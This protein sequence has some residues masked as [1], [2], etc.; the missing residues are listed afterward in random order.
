VLDALRGAGPGRSATLPARSPHPRRV[1]ILT[2]RV[3][4][5]T[6]GQPAIGGA[7]RYGL[8]LAHLLSDLGLS[9][10]FFQQG[11]DWEHGEFF[12]FPVVALPVGEAEGEFAI[13]AA[14]SFAEATTDFDHVLVLAPNYAAG[15]LRDD[16]VVV[17]HGVWWDHDLWAHLEFRTPGWYDR[18]EQVFTR[19]AAVV[20]VDE[21]TIG[22]VRALFP[23]A[24]GRLR[25]IPNSVDTTRFHPPSARDSDVPT[26]VFPRRAEVVRGPRLVGP[27]L[28]QVPDP[29]R[30]V[31][32]GGGDPAMLDVLSTAA[33]EDPRLSVTTA[34]FDDMPAI[35][36]NADV[37]VIPTVASEG[38]SLA[39]LEAMASGCAVI[40]TRVGGLP[41]LVTD[42]VD[43]LVC[44]P[45]PASLADALRRLVRDPW[46]RRRLGD[47]ARRTAALHDRRRWRHAWADLLA[48]HGWIDRTSAAVPYDIVCFS[49]IDWTRRFQRPQQR[50]RAWAR[51]GRR[52]F[53][54]RITEHLDP[55]TRPG[56]VD[57]VELEPGLWEVRLS[58]PDY[59]VYA[60]DIPD[61]LVSAGMAS[62]RTLCERFAIADAVGL[63]ELATW[64]P[65]AVAAR[66]ELGWPIIYDCMDDWSTFPG[67]DERPAFLDRERSLVG[68]TDLMVVSSATIARRWEHARPD[69][70]LARNA[71][72]FEFFAA[73]RSPGS[74]GQSCSGS[75]SPCSPR[76]PPPAPTSRSCWSATSPGWTCRRWRHFRTC[77]SKGCSRTRR[78]PGTSAGSTW[79]S[80]RSWS[81]RPPTGWTWSRSTSTSARACR[82]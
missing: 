77:G 2:N 33:Q 13:G 66:D 29:L 51:R 64:H 24:A 6:T 43:G 53:Y 10:T 26:V 59:D 17:C 4:D 78:C 56:D 11:G 23:H 46:L 55:T 35:Y 19:A 16:A 50:A 12:G 57:A 68:D 15:Q 60:G 75:M 47:A 74:S 3:L 20:S 44:D 18:L 36:R 27:M 25:L 41:E 31:W 40:V 65:L 34:G 49:I 48:E 42:G 8:D 61:D 82:W 14:E 5:R 79:P 9:P 32:V 73:G 81:G 39:A 45:D 1:A 22:V 63:V 54:L 52:V 30:A 76:S 71:T 38:Q 67:F 80:S 62:L 7:E 37:V 72:D 21:S 28:A 70:L 69:L 58:L